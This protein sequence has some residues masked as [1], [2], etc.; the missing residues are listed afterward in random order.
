MK[1][2]R[3][4]YEG[5][6]MVISGTFSGVV[7]DKFGVISVWIVGMDD[8]VDEDGSCGMGV[9]SDGMVWVGR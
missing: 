9:V 3:N 8:G 6:G 5:F 1:F 7:L 2:S 4:E